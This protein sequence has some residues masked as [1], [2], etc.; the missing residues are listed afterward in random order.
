MISSYV[1]PSVE[2]RYLDKQNIK[3]VIDTGINVTKTV[4]ETEKIIWFVQNIS[5]DLFLSIR[6]MTIDTTITPVIVDKTIRV[7]FLKTINGEPACILGSIDASDDF[8]IDF[9]CKPSQFGKAVFLNIIKMYLKSMK[10]IAIVGSLSTQTKQLLV[11]ISDCHNK[12]EIINPNNFVFDKQASSIV[13]LYRIVPKAELTAMM[14]K[15]IF[16]IENIPKILKTDAMVQ[17]H[18]FHVGDV[19]YAEEENLLRLVID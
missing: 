18:G 16:K 11:N 14:K 9:N 3:A 13:P 19:L 17:I 12:I 4:Q 2:S 1:C 7:V 8:K 10:K 15:H 6:Q 5:M